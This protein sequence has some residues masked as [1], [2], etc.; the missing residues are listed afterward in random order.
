MDRI[1]L[2]PRAKQH[3]I[4]QMIDTV[5]QQAGSGWIGRGQAASD[6]ELRFPIGIPQ[7]PCPT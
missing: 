6:D 3:F 4:M 1:Q 7:K 5:L 2:L